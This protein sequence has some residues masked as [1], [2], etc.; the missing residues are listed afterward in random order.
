MKPYG[1]LR[2]KEWALED[3]PREKLMFNGKN[4]LSNAELIAILLGSGNHSESALDVSKK[5]LSLV[6]NN[7]HEL[8]RLSVDQL[9][10]AL[11]RAAVMV[12]DVRDEPEW[13]EGHIEGA[14]HVFVGHIKQRFEDIPRDKPLAI[15]CEWGG[16]ASLAAS[17]LSR[18]G[19][20]NVYVVLGAIRGWKSRGYPLERG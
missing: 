9:K 3:R 5:I 7:L 20:V 4:S 10:K 11:D 13:R 8:S 15:H 17:I 16:R 1:N 19:L 2:I 18:L 12:L 6:D 14:E